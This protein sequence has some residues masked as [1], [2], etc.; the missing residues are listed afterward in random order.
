MISSIN[1]ISIVIPVFKD[2]EGLKV[3]ISQLRKSNIPVAYEIIVCND[4]SN[5]LIT[6]WLTD[7]GLKE[8]KIATQKGSYYARNKGIN[9]A[10]FNWILFVDAG[11]TVKPNWYQYLNKKQERNSYL[12]FDIN[13]DIPANAGLMK[14]YSEF[15]EFRCKSYWE[16]NHFGATAFLL[17]EKRLFEETGLFNEELLSGGDFEFG[18]RCWHAGFKMTFIENN[19]VFHKP[20][21][22]W[23]KYKKQ[24]RVLQGI[25]QLNKSYPSRIKKLPVVSFIEFLK[26]PFKFLYTIKRIKQQPAVIEGKWPLYKV[27]WAEFW[28]QK[29][30]YWALLKVLISKKLRFD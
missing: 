1:G 3:T 14:Q 29:V 10:H 7:Q 23:A 2:L 12:A 21:G 26:G 19:H 24:I 17:V 16:Q 11:V 28:H 27:I 9:Q 15:I 4:G 30:Y 13:L 6:D 5:R 8:I 18:N 22:L 20:R 25:K